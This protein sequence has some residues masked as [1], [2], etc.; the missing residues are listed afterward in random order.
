MQRENSLYIDDSGVRTPISTSKEA[1]SIENAQFQ[2]NIAV[3]QYNAEHC[4]ADNAAIWHQIGAFSGYYGRI[5][6]DSGVRTLI[7][8]QNGLELRIFI[9]IF[10]LMRM[11]IR[12]IVRESQ[13]MFGNEPL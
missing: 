2:A 6:D 12:A 1:K 9:P 4:T 10:V 5:I 7:L 13:R 8:E 3:Y 11:K